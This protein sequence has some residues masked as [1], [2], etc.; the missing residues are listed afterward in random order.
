M[1]RPCLGHN[2]EISLKAAL[3][4]GEG[5]LVDTIRNSIYA[6]PAGHHFE[7]G[8]IPEKTMSRIGG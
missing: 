6:K 7:D 4:A 2:E 3:A 1:L 5:A 8:F